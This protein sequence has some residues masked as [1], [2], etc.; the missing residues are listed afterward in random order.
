M[1]VDRSHTAGSRAATWPAADHHRMLSEA[2]RIIRDAL[3][4]PLGT[5]IVRS[6]QRVGHA[7]AGAKRTRLGRSRADT[8]AAAATRYELGSCKLRIV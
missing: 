5:M 4:V 3:T 6:A 8:G 7:P 1:R 2:R